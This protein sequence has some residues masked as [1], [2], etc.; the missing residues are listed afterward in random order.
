MTGLKLQQHR[1]HASNKA[2]DDDNVTMRSIKIRGELEHQ[3]LE[4]S[5]Q[6]QVV[7]TLVVINDVL[8]TYVCFCLVMDS[9]LHR[10]NIVNLSK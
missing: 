10:N 7:C 8:H 5:T 9:Y 4:H 1:M 2:N 3:L 6:F